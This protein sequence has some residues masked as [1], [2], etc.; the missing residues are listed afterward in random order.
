M[1]WSTDEDC[2]LSEP[3][4]PRNTCICRGGAAK[5]GIGAWKLL[6]A[7]DRIGAV[8]WE[9]S[10]VADKL[11]VKRLWEMSHRGGR[12]QGVLLPKQSAGHADSGNSSVHCH[13]QGEVPSAVAGGTYDVVLQITDPDNI[14]P[15]MTLSIQGRQADGSYRLGSVSLN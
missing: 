4:V 9:I 12:I 5:F 11:P 14:S 1:R 8:T 7:P 13:F 2:F 10:D 3:R 15:P 6:C